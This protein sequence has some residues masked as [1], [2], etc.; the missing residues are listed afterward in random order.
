[1]PHHTHYS[2]TE[3]TRGH[4]D[5]LEVLEFDFVTFVP[6]NLVV[7]FDIDFGTL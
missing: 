5:P 2:F 7:Y 6:D 1:M 4:V 3:F